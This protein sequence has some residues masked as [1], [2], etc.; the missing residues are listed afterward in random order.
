M[1]RMFATASSIGNSSG[2]S[3]R[4]ARKGVA[5]QR[6]LIADGELLDARAAAEEVGAG[7]DDDFRRPVGRRVERD[8]D[9]DPPRVAD[10]RDPLM[11]GQL[12][13]DAERQMPPAGEFERSRWPAGRC[14]KFGSR[15]SV[16]TTRV[17]SAAKM[18]RAVRIA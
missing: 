12:R 15:S 6:V 2:V 16:A 5:L 9:L 8:D 4:R 18:Y 14:R 1:T 11:R 10:D 3:P 7:I 13:R 17:G